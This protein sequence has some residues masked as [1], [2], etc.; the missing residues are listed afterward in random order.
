MRASWQRDVS[1][2]IALLLYGTLG[3][4]ALRQCVRSRRISVNTLGTRGVSEWIALK[5]LKIKTY[6]VEYDMGDVEMEE[7]KH[8]VVHCKKRIRGG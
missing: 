2:L 8:K 4:G 3:S 5:T 7:I 1:T 6:K